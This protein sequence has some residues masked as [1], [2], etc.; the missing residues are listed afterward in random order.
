MCWK[1]KSQT[2]SSPCEKEIISTWCCFISAMQASEAE[3]REEEQIQL[4]TGSRK[5]VLGEGQGEESCGSALPAL[6][7]G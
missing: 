5:R 2:E 1:E 6:G 4:E 3:A 7:Q